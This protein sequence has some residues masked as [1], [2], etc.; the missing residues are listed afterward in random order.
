MW[1]E[2][3]NNFLKI[4]TNYN[5]FL[6][7][8]YNY[9]FFNFFSVCRSWVRGSLRTTSAWATPCHAPSIASTPSSKRFTTS[10]SS[11]SCSTPATS[12]GPPKRPSLPWAESCVPGPGVATGLSQTLIVTGSPVSGAAGSLSAGDASWSTTQGPAGVRASMSLRSPLAGGGAST[13]TGP[14]P[15]SPWA[16]TWPARLLSRPSPSRAPSAGPPRSGPG[17]ACTWCAPGRPVATTGAGCATRSGPG[18]A[19]PPTGLA[20][21]QGCGVGRFFRIPTP[22][23]LKTWLWLQQFWKTDS[24]FSSFEKTTPTPAFLKKQLRLQHFWK[25]DSNSSSFEKTTPTPAFLKKRLRL[26]QFW[27]KRLLLP[28]PAENMRLHWLRLHNP[29]KQRGTGCDNV[30]ICYVGQPNFFSDF[31]RKEFK[32]IL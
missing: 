2:L 13:W 19:W 10:G 17:G 22:A 29:G 30:L 24:D 23:F 28:T 5:F 14:W 11:E 7:F 32:D 26:Q 18:T 15:P 20:K 27:K 4:Y 3:V 1:E 16:G 6:I 31:M 12:A 8:F 21:Q 9:K 25:N